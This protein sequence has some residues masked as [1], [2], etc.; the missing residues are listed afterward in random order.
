M[1]PQPLSWFRALVVAFGEDIKIRVAYK[2]GL[3]IASILTL[4]Y[5]KSVV[6]KYGRSD[7]RY[8]KLGGMAL[9]FW[10]AIQE[11]KNEGITELEMGAL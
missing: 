10:S 7:V 2:N 5:K 1:P 4:S 9:S 6:S 11:A 8:H 3:A